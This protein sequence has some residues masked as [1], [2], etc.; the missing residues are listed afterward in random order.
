M[1]NGNA[2]EPQRTLADLSA[3]V[4]TYVNERQLLR[5]QWNGG[6]FGPGERIRLRFHQRCRPIPLRVA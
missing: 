4:L 3:N 1:W 2:D 5:R 6:C